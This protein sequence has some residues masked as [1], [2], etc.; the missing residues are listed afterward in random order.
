[1]DGQNF[2]KL[3]SLL[4]SVPSGFLVDT[5]WMKRHA[6][7]RQSAAGYVAN[8]WMER[9][10]QGVYRRPFTTVENSKA[11]NGWKIPLLSAQWL[12]KYEFHIGGPSALNLRGHTHYLHLGADPTIYLYGADI[13]SWLLNLHTDARF[14]RRT[15]SLFGSSQPGV[16]NTTFSL[17]E[18][19]D[20]EL[21]LSPWRWPIRMSSPERAILETLDELPANES[22]H[23]VDTLFE[24]LIGLR[25]KMLVSLLT[26]CRSIKVKRLFF[27][28]A[29]KHAHPWRKHIDPARI[30]LGHGDRSLVKG[31]RLHPTYRITVP[32]E[33]LPQ[34]ATDGA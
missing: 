16:E 25:P 21:A 28:Y 4:Q 26:Q 23:I 18:N 14:I 33:L 22:F 10:A 30:D 6:I 3:K 17:A 34:E 24:G 20:N 31:G 32:A 5:N 8:G 12:M 15:T 7:S 9:I 1:M 2:S 19:D 13:P 11:V 29:D 27:I